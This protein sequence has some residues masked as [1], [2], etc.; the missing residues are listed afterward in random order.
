M[1]QHRPAPAHL[2]RCFGRRRPASLRRPLP[3]LL[4][5]AALGCGLAEDPASEA[6]RYDLLASLPAA[7]R[8]CDGTVLDVGSQPAREALLSGFSWNER[9][10]EESFAWSVGP[11]SE[12][13]TTV[14][15]PRPMR[16]RGRALAWAPPGAP[17]T[18]RQTVSPTLISPAGSIVT[19]L[20]PISL[21]PGAGFE[22]FELEVDAAALGAGA[23]RLVFGYSFTRHS[24]EPDAERDL[25]VG[26]SAVRLEDDS[27]D[28]SA[29]ASWSV[30]GGEGEGAG[31]AAERGILRL[32]RGERVAWPLELRRGDRLVIER[33]DQ[34]AVDALVVAIVALEPGRLPESPD[35]GSVG[36]AIVL[37]EIIGPQRRV[38]IA[39]PVRAGRWAP[40]RLMLAPRGGGVV[41]RAARIVG[42]S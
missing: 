10:G 20:G 38:E 16:L 8:E 39:L 12:V 18:L 23:N 42:S 31:G 2:R 14:L 7:V 21:V 26:W 27:C 9:S 25:A 30:D 17:P 36:E 32:G 4:F 34:R 40:H 15:V 13:R 29:A 3:P 37:P 22:D 6:L 19:A 41:L 35:G 11:R 1:A 24:F 5:A 28:P 33:V